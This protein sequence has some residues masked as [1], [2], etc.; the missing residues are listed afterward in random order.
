MNI[1]HTTSMVQ[2]RHQYN[3][4]IHTDDFQQ[5]QSTEHEHELKQNNP[6]RKTSLDKLLC[7][8]LDEYCSHDNYGTGRR[9]NN[10]KKFTL[11]VSS[12]SKIW[13]MNMNLHKSIH[14]GKQA[15]INYYVRH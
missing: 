15:E 6:W 4:E 10:L 13:I 2:V 1:A 9:A 8:T 12:T 11:M 14:G 3:K 7:E 5:Q